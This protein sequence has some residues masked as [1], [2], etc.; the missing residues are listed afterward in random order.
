MDT[1]W[2]IQQCL[3][4]CWLIQ[5]VRVTEEKRDNCY[6]HTEA[7]GNGIWCEELEFHSSGYCYPVDA[8]YEPGFGVEQGFGRKLVAHEG[9]VA[10]FACGCIDS[11]KSCTTVRLKEFNPPAGDGAKCTSLEDA[12]WCN[13]TF[14]TIAFKCERL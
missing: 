5:S 9:D 4:P 6:Y 12:A 7:N 1:P 14:D 13:S 10:S 11:Y 8:C 2:D 3:L